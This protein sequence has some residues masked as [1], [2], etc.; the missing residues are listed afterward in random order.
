VP[1]INKEHARKIA[2]KLG[3]TVD[4]SGKA[5][6]LACVYYRGT[7]VATFGIRRGSR[8]SLAHGHIPNDLHL[9]PHDILRLANCPMSQEEWIQHMK[10]IDLIPEDDAEGGARE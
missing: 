6:D 2:K 3:A 5:H 8:K 9:R 10:D 7:L 4:R 1:P